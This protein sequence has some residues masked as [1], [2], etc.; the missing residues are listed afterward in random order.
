M[1]QS[2]LASFGQDQGRLSSIAVLDK[3]GHLHTRSAAVIEILSRMN[4]PCPVLAVLV[5]AVPEPLRDSVYEWVSRNRHAFGTES[6]MCRIP[7]DDEAS[8]FVL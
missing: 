4:I 2:L 5:K 7:E 6:Q 1:G 8:R 3:F